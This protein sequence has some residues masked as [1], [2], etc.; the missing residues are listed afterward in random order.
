M[1]YHTV[2]IPE[3]SAFVRLDLEPVFSDTP[4]GIRD[5][6]IGDA[7]Q[8]LTSV[9]KRNLYSFQ[10]GVITVVIGILFVIAGVTG[11]IVMKFTGID[12]ISFGITCIMVGYIGFNDTL[13]LQILTG[14]PDIIRVS[15]YMCLALIS[16]PMLS[17]FSSITGEPHSKLLS[18]MLALCLVNF[19]SQ[20]VL[21]LSGLSDYYYLVYVSQIIIFACLLIAVVIIVKAIRLGRIKPALLRS[22]TWGLGGCILGAVIDMLR[23][24]FL[25]SYGS[26]TFTRIGVLLFTAFMGIYLYRDHIDSL[27]KKEQESAVFASEISEAFAKVIDMKDR[28]TNGHSERVAK[29]TAMIAKEMG[30][31]TETVEKYYRIGL[32]HDVG[33][34]GIPNAVLNKPG[35]LTEEEYDEIKTHTL[36]GNEILK[37]I[38]IVP[39]LAVGALSHHERHDGKGYPY[40]L[41]GDDIPQVARIIAVADAFDA[42]YSDRQYRKRMDFEK[43]ISIIREV[44]GSQLNPEVVDAFLRLVDKGVIKAIEAKET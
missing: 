20:V 12:F 25:Q 19:L 4:V 34:V 14:R 30:Y 11:Q 27:K 24:Y 38:S 41:S 39:E 7:G 17:F 15:E 1:Q 26:L 9:F 23:F 16:F 10:Q 5:I 40:G 31:D 43:V 28:Y 2:P 6:T 37:D 29:Y 35:K 8:F 3:G 44:S 32:L 18:G 33:K 22:V 42:M 21:T 36:K 13:L